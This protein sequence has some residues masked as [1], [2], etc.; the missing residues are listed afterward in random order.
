MNLKGFNNIG[1]TCYL[2]SGLQMIVHNKDLCK[3]ILNNTHRNQTIAE[4]G[5]FI[6]EYHNNNSNSI[7]PS[8]IKDFISSKNIIFKGYGQQDSSEFIIYMLDAINEELKKNNDNIDKLYEH[9]ANISIKCKLKVCLNI[10][11]HEEKNN[12]MIFDLKEEFKDLDDCYNEFVKRFKFE[13]DCLYYCDKC[14][15]DTIAS[16]RNEIILWPKHLIII[17][18]RFQ[19]N[20]MRLSKNDNEIYIP[21]FWKN[22]YKLKGIVFHSGSLHGGHYVYI[23][24]YNNKWYLFNDD[25][26]SEINDDGLNRFKNYGYIYYFEKIIFE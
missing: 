1:N 24:N 22:D 16:K 13:N 9:K 10:S 3:I 14:K 6:N 5:N 2:N 23:G 7:T 11:T 17:L 20:G 26:V 15:R 21:F 19:Q 18:K 8:Y 25:H 4:I 12:F